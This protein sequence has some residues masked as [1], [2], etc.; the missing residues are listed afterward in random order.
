MKI[1]CL[2]LLIIP[3]IIFSQNY[4]SPESIEYNSIT[5]NYFISNSGNGQILKLVKS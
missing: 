5:G 2:Q 4:N 1:L 3:V